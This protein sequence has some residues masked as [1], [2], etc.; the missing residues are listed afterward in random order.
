MKKHLR[1]IPLVLALLLCLPLIAACKEE[2]PNT[3]HE[4]DESEE[5]AETSEDNL[6]ANL[7][8]NGKEVNIY[9]WNET[10][11]VDF[12]DGILGIPVSD[13]TYKSRT[14]VEERLNVNFNVISAP[15]NWDNRNT[16]IS[17]LENVLLGGGSY[18]IVGQ[19]TPAAPIGAMKGLYKNLNNSDY[20][21]LSQPWWP[22][23]INES[24]SIGGNVY[25]CS[26]DITAT[27]INAIG[28]V[29]INLDLMEDYGIEGDI[30]EIVKEKEW[31]MEKMKTMFLGVVGSVDGGSSSDKKYGVMIGN[32][33]VYDNLF[34]AGGLKL[35]EHDEDDQLV[36]STDVTQSKMESWFSTCHNL[37][38]DYDDVNAGDADNGLTIEN[39][40][41]MENAILYM[42]QELNDAKNYLRNAEF[43][44]A[45]VPY[46]MYDDDQKEY[47]SITGYW[48]TMF[49]IPYN[50]KDSALCEIVLQ[51]LGSDAYH[52]ITPT[53]YTESFQHR[54]LSTPENAEMLDLI[55]DSIVYD[56]GRIF[57]DNIAMFNIFRWAF[58][59]TNWKTEFAKNG[60]TWIS[61]IEKVTNTLG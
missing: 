37:L 42:S 26:G 20:L 45:V 31:T 7:N 30:Y 32:R 29:F 47:C 55:H 28:S 6:P 34:F 39:T 21:D 50:V 5:F 10:L 13:A 27:C 41:M 60:D 52:N 46:P 4:G 14:A 8:Y 19:Y 51:A 61:N 44:F 22:G 40:F 24:C 18:D 11:D 25:F 58:Y 12:A 1:I 59:D 54:F 53:V 48:V 15:G 3:N 9:T 49:S 38:W 56:T 57:A 2:K 16:F 33:G 23:S 35:V 43:D 17:G 36:I